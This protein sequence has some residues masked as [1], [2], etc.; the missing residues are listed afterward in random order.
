MRSDMNTIKSSSNTWNGHLR[1]AVA[2]GGYVI[3]KV[4]VAGLFALLFGWLVK[5]LWNWILPEVLGV[6]FISYWQAFGIVIL[7]HLILGTAWIHDQVLLRG[8]GRRNSWYLGG[9][10]Y[11]WLHMLDNFYDFWYEKGNQAFL[12]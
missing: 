5:L 12:D 1:R 10:P 4:L 9:D 2:V 8:K 7:A 6:G 3:L 11:N